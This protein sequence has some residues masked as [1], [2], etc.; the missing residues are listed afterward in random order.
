LNSVLRKTSLGES[1]ASSKEKNRAYLTIDSV[2][3]YYDQDF[4]LKL[5]MHADKASSQVA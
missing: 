2:D 5:T 4:F 1:I 3:N